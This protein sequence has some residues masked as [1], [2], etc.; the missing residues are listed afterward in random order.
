[1]STIAWFHK[2]MQEGDLVERIPGL[3][4]QQGEFAGVGSF[5]LRAT[6]KDDKSISLGIK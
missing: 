4:L 1:M 2:I 3:K 5:R 6:P